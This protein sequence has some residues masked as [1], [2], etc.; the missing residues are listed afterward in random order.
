MTY[1]DRLCVQLFTSCNNIYMETQVG[2]S[3]LRLMDLLDNWRRCIQSTQEPSK[4]FSIDCSG[5][6]HTAAL[7]P[8][9]SPLNSS[10]KDCNKAIKRSC[11][12]CEDTRNEKN[13]AG[14]EVRPFFFLLFRCC[15]FYP[16]LMFCSFSPLQAERHTSVCK[17]PAV[18]VA[19]VSS[20]AEL[21]VQ[22]TAHDACPPTHVSNAGF[23]FFFARIRLN[24]AGRWIDSNTAQLAEPHQSCSAPITPHSQEG[25]TRKAAPN[26]GKKVDC[27]ECRAFD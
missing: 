23:F 19:T 11:P 8:V 12:V 15:F 9:S 27:P 1:E 22:V 13:R 16:L 5:R 24:N 4:G 14:S 18:C 6:K 26:W 3:V 10:K 25:F 2:R 7:R 17:R 20:S 21:A